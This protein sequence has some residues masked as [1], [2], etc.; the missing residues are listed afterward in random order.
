MQISYL[1]LR[2]IL[3]PPHSQSAKSI[4]LEP[5]KED[6][7]HID[8][9]L[10]L[11]K[12]NFDSKNLN[13][14][15]LMVRDP[16]TMVM[17]NITINSKEDL[18]KLLNNKIT[19]GASVGDMYRYG[20]KNANI[21]L[22][23]DCEISSDDI[24]AD[25][26]ENTTYPKYK[27]AFYME[28]C[29]FY[30]N[31][32]TIKITKGTR[33]MYPLFGDLKVRDYFQ[34]H[35]KDLNLVY[36]GDLCGTGFAQNIRTEYN[37]ESYI[38]E[39]INIKV[40]GN[41]LPDMYERDMSWNPN[42]K[43]HIFTGQAAGFAFRMASAKLNNINIHVSGDIGLLDPQVKNYNDGKYNK[44]EIGAYGFISDNG[45]DTF[46]NTKNSKENHFRD[47]TNLNIKVDGSI[48]AG[49]IHSIA[50]AAGL[51]YNVQAK[52]FKDVKLEVK[53]DIKAINKG[54]TGIEL[55][56]E[57]TPISATGIAHNI[58]YLENV[59]VKIGGSI[60]SENNVQLSV[61]TYACG[62]GA[63][64]YENRLDKKQGLLE[65]F[66]LTIKNVNLSVGGDKVTP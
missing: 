38:I 59:E 49:S 1:K 53:G 52:K 13:T 29:N 56:T 57:H 61:P 31:S 39:N 65:S 14:Q 35:I 24:N 15:A 40:N 12:N 6:S 60:E 32:H 25:I 10:S 66:P 23:A 18:I 62:I 11:E 5:I 28:N 46:G 54:S 51:G 47:V 4:D 21:T 34:S 43:Y 42:V 64:D 58:H 36:E 55:G 63:W 50:Q 27:F 19:V 7:L 30:G 48:L 22:N 3:P 9:L 26:T 16:G 20:V 33:E 2:K 41:L 17:E 45:K 37:M 44:V 8:R